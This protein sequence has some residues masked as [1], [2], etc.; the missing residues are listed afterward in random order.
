L[1]DTLPEFKDFE[2]RYDW[3]LLSQILVDILEEEA[4]Q[5]L[6]LAYASVTS[7]KFRIVICS[8][9]MNSRSSEF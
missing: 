4:S 1:A 8:R 6:N 7:K 5:V 9:Q 2:N 3:P